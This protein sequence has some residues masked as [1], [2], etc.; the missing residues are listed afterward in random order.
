MKIEVSPSEVAELLDILRGRTPGSIEQVPG[1][2]HLNIEQP[3]ARVSVP[4]EAVSV[5]TEST[6]DLAQQVRNVVYNEMS[7]FLSDIE[8]RVKQAYD[9][10]NRQGGIGHKVYAEDLNLQKHQV[11]GYTIT[12]NSPTAGSVAWASV[13]VVYNGTDYAITDGN[14]ANKYIWFDPAA[15]N[16]TTTLQSSNTKPDLTAKP[17]AALLF[18]NN[19]GTPVDVLKSSMPVALANGAVD[20]S[21]ILSGAVGSGA[22]ASGAVTSTAIASGAVG[23]G[24]LASGAV[25]S[26]A[27]ASGAVGSTQLGSNAVTS[28]KIASGAVDSTSLASGAVTSTAI[29]SGAVGTSALAANAVDST[30]IAGGAV[31]TT[32]LASGAVTATNIASGAVGAAQITTGSITA[33]KLNT[34]QHLLY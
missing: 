25:T 10:E 2:V 34:L 29:A 15:T 33:S 13:H 1:A 8:F 24:A 9:V 18:V 17:D 11:T 14:T 26:T 30:K 32:Q 27:I 23:S 28:G 3:S 7:H 22:L 19:G 31:G 20:S 6:P 16:G 21:S 4:T 5:S 12:A